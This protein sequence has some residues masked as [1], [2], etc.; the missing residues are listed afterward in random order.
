MGLL[1]GLSSMGKSIDA[2]AG[3][4]GLA[5]QKSELAA[6]QLRLADALATT[7]ESA[8]RAQAAD[9]AQAAQ[10]REFGF[11]SGESAL[12][13]ANRLA[14]TGMTVAGELER[15]KI[16]SNAPTPDI[17]MAEWWKS[18]TP[19]ARD[20]FTAAKNA[21][22]G[23]PSDWG[24]PNA[25]RTQA[26]TSTPPANTEQPPTPSLPGAPTAPATPTGTQKTGITVPSFVNEPSTYAINEDALSKIP[27]SAQPLVKNII[28]GRE[29]PFPARVAATQYGR[30]VMDYVRQVEPNFDATTWASR[31]A[32]RK[33]FTEGKEA[34]AINAANTTM[35][36]A[37]HLMAQFEELGN[38][39]LGESVNGPANALMKKFGQG[40][41]VRATEGTIQALASEARKVYAGVSG[42][43]VS[44]LN[45]WVKAFPVNGSKDE[46]RK[47]M[48]N[49]VELLDGK[50]ESLATQYNRGMGTSIQPFQMLDPKPAAVFR[51]LLNREPVDTTGYQGGKPPG[52]SRPSG[53]N[54]AAATQDAEAGIKIPEPPAGFRIIQ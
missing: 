38:W 33:G 47:A 30:R 2:Y 50:L 35:N 54:A 39:S 46:Q 23:L 42:G 17:K 22:L 49:F 20:A 37:G 25:S 10:G 26:P 14:T 34:S 40:G 27:E 52:A 43:S 29:Q 15:A 5:A 9:I 21:E 6:E 16:T 41:T 11:K 3:E 8:G 7:R 31:L 45:E 44:E 53:P 24:S 51:A 18:A 19:E 13:R 36:H 48:E 32:T 28:L 12:D 4:V 1:N